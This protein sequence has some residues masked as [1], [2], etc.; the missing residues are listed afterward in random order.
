VISRQQVPNDGSHAQRSQSWT[1]VMT[2]RGCQ[3]IEDAAHCDVSVCDSWGRLVLRWSGPWM[4]ALLSCTWFSAWSAASAACETV[5]WHRIVLVTGVRS[6]PRHS[7]LARVC[8]SSMLD[9]CAT[10]HC[11]S[12]SGVVLD[13][14]QASELSPASKDVRCAVSPG[15]ELCVVIAWLHSCGVLLKSQSLVQDDTEHF[16]LLIHR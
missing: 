16:H 14:M 6:E 4:W 8:W 7:A 15:T 11:S 9:H 13:Y 2:A 5:A 12:L 3:T 10:E 1:K